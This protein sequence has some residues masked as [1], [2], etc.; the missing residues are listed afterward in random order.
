MRAA[1]QCA[2]LFFRGF[3]H[4]LCRASSGRR[5][6]RDNNNN[7]SV[8]STVNAKSDGDAAVSPFLI[9][10]RV[11]S[12]DF[13]PALLLTDV[14]LRIDPA[15]ERLASIAPGASFLIRKKSLTANGAQR[16]ESPIGVVPEKR[17]GRKGER[18]RER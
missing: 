9:N 1:L 5:C 13:Y 2:D 4:K 11:T 18:E 7:N 12:T 14:N 6:P 3:R 10:A 16:N 17:E 15:S 8:F